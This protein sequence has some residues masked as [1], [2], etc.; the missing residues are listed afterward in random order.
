M[1]ILP[2]T[3]V[4]GAIAVV[5]AIQASVQ[6]L[7]IP[8]IRSKISDYITLSLGIASTIPNI[9]TTVETLLAAADAGL[10][11]ARERGRNGFAIT[12]IE[13]IDPIPS[14]RNWVN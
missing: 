13:S 3:D 14:R 1:I 6:A 9:A 10:Y 12:P 7:A 2:N 8:H 11:K 5:Q 4:T